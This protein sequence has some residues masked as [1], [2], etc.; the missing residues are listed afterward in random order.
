MTFDERPK[1]LWMVSAIEKRKQTRG[2]REFV[3]SNRAMRDV[4]GGEGDMSI[5]A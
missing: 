3:I 1:N 5:K 4:G 2:S